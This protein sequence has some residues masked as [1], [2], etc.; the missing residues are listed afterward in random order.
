M[1]A[2]LGPN[3]AGKTTTLRAISGLVKPLAGVIRVRGDDLVEAV[4][5]GAG[6]D[7]DRP[8][9]RG[10]R[11]V[12]RADGRRAPAPRVTRANGSTPPPP[13]RTSRRSS[14]SPTGAPGCSPAASSRCSRSAGRWHGG[15]ACMLLD[16]LSLGLAP[17]IVERLMP[18]V[19][20]VR[21]GERV[22]GAAGR[23][24]HP[25]RARRSPTVATCCRTASSW[26]TSA[27]RC[28][29]RDQQ[30][31]LSSYLGERSSDTSVTARVWR[32]RGL[33]R[34]EGCQAP[35]RTPVATT[36]IGRVAASWPVPDSP[37]P[38][39]RQP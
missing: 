33:I 11:R 32:P 4:A 35:V 27:P 23:A 7:G 39:R 10:P 19:S 17:V 31:V 18:V 2:L 34:G 28:C 15:R 3:G 29:A 8:R 20:Q 14:T 21:A 22:R 1:V 36:R 13:T 30:L 6:A 5:H 16:E 26:C 12:L 25:H 37:S 38:I 24:A 9:A